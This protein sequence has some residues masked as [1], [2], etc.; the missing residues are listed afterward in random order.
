M[1]LCSTHKVGPWSE[2]HQNGS[3]FA[4][5]CAVTWEN[6]RMLGTHSWGFCLQMKKPHPVNFLKVD[7]VLQWCVFSMV[8]AVQLDLKDTCGKSSLSCQNYCQVKSE[9]S[10]LENS[11][12]E[13]I[14]DG[15]S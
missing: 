5:L 7:C 2:R 3:D 12:V 11:L 1:L 14:A 8:K 10:S 9:E 15:K 4:A 13:N 6:S